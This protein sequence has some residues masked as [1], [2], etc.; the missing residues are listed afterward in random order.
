M[1]DTRDR[2]LCI[3][4]V[5]NCSNLPKIWNKLVKRRWSPRVT[6]KYDAVRSTRLW[7]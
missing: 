1:L 7:A 4:V 6:A 3:A 2:H 5:S